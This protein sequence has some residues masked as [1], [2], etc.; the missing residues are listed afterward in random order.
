MQICCDVEVTWV[1][2]SC[3]WILLPWEVTSRPAGVLPQPRGFAGKTRRPCN[4]AS[5]P[6][7]V[8]TWCLCHVDYK[9]AVPVQ[10]AFAD[11]QGLASCTCSSHQSTCVINTL[12][13]H[14]SHHVSSLHWIHTFAR[15]AAVSECIWACLSTDWHMSS[16]FAVSIM[17]SLSSEV[18][19]KLSMSKCYEEVWVCRSS[20]ALLNLLQHLVTC[21]YSPS[22]TTCRIAQLQGPSQ[23]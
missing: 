14:I 8:V 19:T 2:A 22:G 17:T 20:W 23:Q 11:Q 13:T 1:A 7:V 15:C 21:A 6:I 10:P 5:L 12:Y 9:H 3:S 4:I 18:L 16:M